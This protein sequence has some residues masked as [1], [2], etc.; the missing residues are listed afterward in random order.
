MKKIIF[1]I[2]VFA[3]FSG[4]SRPNAGSGKYI[5]A[6]IGNSTLSISGIADLFKHT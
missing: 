1:A 6:G 3:T 2:L 4:I 5:T